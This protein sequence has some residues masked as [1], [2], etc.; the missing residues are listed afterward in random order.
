MSIQ[1]GMETFKMKKKQNLNSVIPERHQCVE[2][3]RTNCLFKNQ[4]AMMQLM[5]FFQMKITKSILLNLS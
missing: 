5:D 1:L 2:W 4:L 3:K